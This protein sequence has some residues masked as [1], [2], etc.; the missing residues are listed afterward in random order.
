MKISNHTTKL[1]SDIVINEGNFKHCSV[2]FNLFLGWLCDSNR[3]VR[4][5]G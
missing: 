1:G 4:Q 5:T 3:I 2:D